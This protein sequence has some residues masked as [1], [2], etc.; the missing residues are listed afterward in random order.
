MY[1]RYQYFSLKI[2]KADAI[3][4]SA[5]CHTCNSFPPAVQQQYFPHDNFVFLINIYNFAKVRIKKNMNRT[6]LRAPQA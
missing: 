2:D 5:L 4:Q 1:E 6:V 3:L